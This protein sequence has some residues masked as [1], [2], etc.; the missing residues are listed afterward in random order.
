MAGM[1]A[2]AP[3][4]QLPVFVFGCT[5]FSIK[6]PRLAPVQFCHPLPVSKLARI[7]GFSALITE[8]ADHHNRKW[9]FS[10]P[11]AIVRLSGPARP[12]GA[13]L[14]IFYNVSQAL[15]VIEIDLHGSLF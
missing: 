10:F 4:I 2:L 9:S 6:G 11:D 5:L 13:V 3:T 7:F 8:G 15:P 12:L 1:T 14:S